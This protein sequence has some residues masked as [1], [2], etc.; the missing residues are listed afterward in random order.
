MEE[1]RIKLINF[2]IEH[3]MDELETV[4]DALKI[5]KMSIEELETNAKDIKRYYK[6]VHN[7][8]INL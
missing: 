7:T 2:I 3:A 1:K 8:I 6:E 4:Q 5:A